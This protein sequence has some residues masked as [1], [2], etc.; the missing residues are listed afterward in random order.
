[1][2]NNKILIV[3]FSFGKMNK[4]RFQHVIYK[5]KQIFQH[6]YDELILGPSIK[7]SVMFS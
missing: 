5:I 2:K 3:E 4:E 1:M 7:K 6:P